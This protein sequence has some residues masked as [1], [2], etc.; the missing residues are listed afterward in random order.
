MNILE[1]FE[2]REQKDKDIGIEIEIE[3]GE[4]NFDIKKYW[5]IVGD[6]SLHGGGVEF[7]LRNPVHRDKTWNRLKSLR[8]ELKQNNSILNP[9]DRCG[10]HIHV[11]CQTLTT[12]QVINFALVYLILEEK[13]VGWCGEHREGNLFCLRASDAEEIVKGLIYSVQTNSLANMQLDYYRYASINLSALKKFGSVEFRAL[14]T[15]KD[16]KIIQKWIKMLL[17]IKDYSL[18]YEEARHIIEEI[19][20]T[21]AN[22]FVNDVLQKQ[23]HLISQIKINESIMEG[24]RRIQEVAYAEIQNPLKYDIKP[25]TLKDLQIRPAEPIDYPNILWANR[26]ERED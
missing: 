2:V 21:G 25:V 26:E 17:N 16:F 8:D 23:A 1:Y 10:V 9:N 24:V 3:G 11:N 22:N 12:K 7:V 19:S 18:K 20:M 13:L 15:P 14:Q 4:L 5:K 6:G